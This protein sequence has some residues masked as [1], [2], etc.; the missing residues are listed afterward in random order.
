MGREKISWKKTISIALSA[1]IIG[2]LIFLMIEVIWG[3]ILRGFLDVQYL[4]GLYVTSFLILM[5][6]LLFSFFIMV[7]LFMVLLKGKRETE[8]WV[9]IISGVLTFITIIIISYMTVELA[10]PEVFSVL[11]PLDKLMSLPQYVVYFSVYILE[12]PILLWDISLVIFTIWAI[13]FTKLLIYEV[14]KKKKL[15]DLRQRIY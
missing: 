13:I 6:G 10:Y 4:S 9:V 15:K 3:D 1:L 5:I 8:F 11:S 2:Y 7:I 12:S 14:R